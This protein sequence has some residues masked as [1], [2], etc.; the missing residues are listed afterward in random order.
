MR[1]LT[2]LFVVA[3]VCVRYT[4]C[5]T[6]DYMAPEVLQNKGHDEAC[7]W[8][9]L[10]N[11]CFEL[12]TGLPPFYCQNDDIETVEKIMNRKIKWPDSMDGNAKDLID[13]L[14]QVRHRFD[15][16]CGSSEL[17]WLAFAVAACRLSLVSSV[18]ASA[19]SWLKSF[20]PV[21]RIGVHEGH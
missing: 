20:V 21:L 4:L 6:L 1:G 16:C 17:S 11:V 18:S 19:S 8:W 15:T 3:G 12:L 2:D 9:S 7:D 13:R 14:V 5:G 10:G